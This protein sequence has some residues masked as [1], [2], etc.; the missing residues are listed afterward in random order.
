MKELTNKGV[1]VKVNR[2]NPILKT[3]EIQ[4]WE[5]AVLNMETSTGLYSC[6]FFYNCKLVAFRACEEHRNLDASQFTISTDPETGVQYVE[7]MGRASKNIQ[8]GLK[9]KK[10]ETTNNKHF[11]QKEN[12]RCV[13]K[14]YENYLDLIPRNGPFWGRPLEETLLILSP[15]NRRSLVQKLLVKTD[16]Q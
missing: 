6:V 13:V 14:I 15:E 7:F 1:G 11:E 9:H 8:G 12:P 10:V 4:L 2:A 5:T 3:G 16:W